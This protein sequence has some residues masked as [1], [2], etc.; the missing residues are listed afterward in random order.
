MSVALKGF[1]NSPLAPKILQTLEAKRKLKFKDLGID[2]AGNELLDEQVI[3]LLKP[4]EVK[5]A[6]GI[7]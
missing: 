2:E 4:L 3:D 7:V 5:K 6:E 1:R